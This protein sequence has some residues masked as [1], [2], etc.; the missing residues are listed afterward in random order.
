MRPFISAVCITLFLASGAVGAD[1]KLVVPQLV[2]PSGKPVEG[3]PFREKYDAAWSNYER[4]IA[5]VT[6]R[7]NAAL[8]GRFN[9]AA[10]AGNFHLA[11]MWEKMKQEFADTDALEW[12]TDGKA[13]TEWRR[14]FKD[15]EFPED[16][17]DVVKSAGDDYAEAVTRLKGDYD[18]LV[19]AY[20]KSKNLDRAEQLL[21]EGASLGSKPAP[22]PT[23]PGPRP[24]P[25][26]PPKPEPPKPW[27]VP[28]KGAQQ[29]K[30]HWY[31]VFPDK[32]TWQQAKAKCEEMGGHLVVVHDANEEAFIKNLA[33]NA[34][35][36]NVW[37]GASDQAQEGR[38]VWV[39]GTPLN[40]ANWGPSQPNNKDNEE[41]YLSLRVPV[42]LWWDLKNLA[43]PEYVIGFV[44]EWND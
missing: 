32:L 35:L 22:P 21:N 17:G 7:V 4:S 16:F 33:A 6:D 38:W 42:S 5:A 28:K 12:P 44:C 30:G 14:K 8:D 34:G 23:P 29:F 1:S 15:I 37:L 10:D 40:Y 43:P 26:H 31:K 2:K 24:A 3:D 18:A 36:G 39:D 9:T 19:R 25:P 20:T 11:K 41:H 27:P 13:K